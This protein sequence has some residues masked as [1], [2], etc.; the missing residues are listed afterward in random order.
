MAAHHRS[1]GVSDGPLELPIHQK[2]LHESTVQGANAAQGRI[3]PRRPQ[4]PEGSPAEY[5]SHTAAMEAAKKY[6]DRE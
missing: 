3:G 5:E 6:L 4:F 1:S 2:P